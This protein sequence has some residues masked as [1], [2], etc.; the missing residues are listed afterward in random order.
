M[1]HDVW[2]PL[3]IA[4]KAGERSDPE[5]R[6]VQKWLDHLV[7]D[8]REPHGYDLALARWQRSLRG[9]GDRMLTGQ[10]AGRLL[11]G[12]GNPSPTEVGLS[13]HR[14]WGVPFIPGS[15]LKG[16]LAHWAEITLGPHEDMNEDERA[17]R[18]PW[19]GPER[20]ERGNAVRRPGEAY[21]RVFGAPPLRGH[22]RSARRGKLVV[23]D[24][25]WLPGVD[26]NSRT[27]AALAPDVLTVHQRRYYQGDEPWPSDGD[28]PIPVS[29]ITVRPGTKFLFAVSSDDAEIADWAADALRCVLQDWGVGGKTAAGYGRFE[30]VVLCDPPLLAELGETLEASKRGGESEQDRLDLLSAEWVERLRTLPLSGHAALAK[31]LRKYVKS[32]KKRPQLDALLARIIAP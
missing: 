31:L 14:T 1:A 4:E 2:S 28:D 9:R 22:E 24:A 29:F 30:R 13:L 23:H 6:G 21:E 26:K 5:E 32:K 10:A 7:A 3:V 19:A 11:V 12:H 27:K 8:D 18:A 16:L 15:A 17:H 20:D 25:L